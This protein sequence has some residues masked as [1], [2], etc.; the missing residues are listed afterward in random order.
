MGDREGDGDHDHRQHRHRP[1][2]Q[3]GQQD[4]LAAVGGEAAR[5][6]ASQGRPSEVAGQ[7]EEEWHPE[8]V[9]PTDQRVGHRRSGDIGHHPRDGAEAHQRMEHNAQQQR[10]A[11]QGVQAGQ[12]VRRHGGGGSGGRRHGFLRG[13]VRVGV[14]GDH[15]E[16]LINGPARWLSLSKPLVARGLAKLDQRESAVH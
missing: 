16:P 5:A 7:G 12:P 9:D 15:W 2:H 4:S 1:E 14:G 13:E 11:T 3:Q 6:L 10:E 8:Q